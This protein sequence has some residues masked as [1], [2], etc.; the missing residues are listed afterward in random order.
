MLRLAICGN[1]K[2]VYMR[3]YVLID[4]EYNVIRF[5]SYSINETDYYISN[6]DTPYNIFKEEDK[7]ILKVGN[8]K[9][10]P[11]LYP[12]SIIE[13]YE[14]EYEIPDEIK[15]LININYILNEL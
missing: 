15:E 14:L 8:N 12:I 3:Y 4:N 13:E 6:D 9:I 11:T 7:Y 5:F 1:V 2:D 10:Y